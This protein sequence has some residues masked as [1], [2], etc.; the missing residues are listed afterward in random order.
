MIGL[1]IT[2]SAGQI[3]GLQWHLEFIIKKKKKT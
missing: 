1:Q 3:L 2:S